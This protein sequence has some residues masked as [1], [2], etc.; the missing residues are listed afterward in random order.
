MVTITRANCAARLNYFQ[1]MLLMLLAFKALVAAVLL[2]SW[3]VPR[4]VLRWRTFQRWR[5]E[6]K[7]PRSTRE[8][9][10]K[11]RGSVLERLQATDWVKVWACCGPC[12]RAL[13]LWP[14]ACSQ[15]PRSVLSSSFFNDAGVLLCFWAPP[16]PPQ[17]LPPRTLAVHATYN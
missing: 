4:V 16:P 10:R 2:L 8:R 11:R 9:Q 6:P 12:H 5:K 17:T 13:V 1:S 14:V 7:H 3:A 15:P